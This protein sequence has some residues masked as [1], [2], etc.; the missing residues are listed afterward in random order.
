MWLSPR[1][2]SIAVAAPIVKRP[3]CPCKR[4]SVRHGTKRP[5]PGAFGAARNLGGG[6]VS[7]A[8]GEAVEATSSSGMLATAST[9]SQA[10]GAGTP[11]EDDSAGQV[12]GEVVNNSGE[13][14]GRL[15]ESPGDEV[16][17]LVDTTGSVVGDLVSTGN[18]EEVG[19]L[20]AAKSAAMSGW[21][22]ELLALV[23]D[24]PVRNSSFGAWEV[25]VVI[26]LQVLGVMAAG[27][28]GRR[29]INDLVTKAEEKYEERLPDQDMDS[30]LYVYGFLKAVDDTSSYL[31]IGAS[32]IALQRTAVFA[33][34]VFV[35]NDAEASRVLG[36]TLDVALL[37]VLQ[38]TA[39]LL[40]KAGALYAIALV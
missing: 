21:A 10:L 25:S 39:W 19:A 23:G 6:V 12:I 1:C 2:F 38:D 30:E 37:T 11:A 31:T 8:S 24:H 20:I 35:I 26:G 9:L 28:G 17:V 32:L 22:S 18:K 7:L 5:R 16:G 27:T 36:Q 40:E 3:P 29:L 15:M 33:Q 14:L 13:V 4:L 34:D